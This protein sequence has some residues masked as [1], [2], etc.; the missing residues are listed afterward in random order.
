MGTLDDKLDYLKET[1]EQIRQ[2]INS[3]GQQVSTSDTFR[4]YA[5]KISAIDTVN[6]QNKTVT[7]NGVYSADAGYSGLGNVTV[8]LPL[9]TKRITVNGTYNASSDDLEGYSSVTVAVE[10]VP[11]VVE[12]VNVTPTTSAQIIRP[13]TGVDGFS[14]VNVS[15]VTSAI[16]NNITAQNIVDGVQILGVSGSAVVLDGEEINITPTTSQQVITPTSPRN[17]ITQATVAAVDHTIDANIIA[18][19]IKSGVEIL[20]VEGTYSGA[21]INNQN[22]NVT[23]STS[24]QE[25]TADNGY[26]GL[27]TVNVSAV[28]S[29]IDENI[30]AANIVDG[31]SILG[32]IGSAE[33]ANL[34]GVG[35]NPSTEMQNVRPEAPYNGF[36]VVDV[37][38]VDAT[39]DE[40]I[41]ASNIKSGVTIL[42][43]TGDYQGTVINN[44]NKSVIPSA[45]DQSIVA[46]VGYTGLGTVTVS[47][48]EDLVANNIKSGVNIF[49]VVGNVVESNTTTV[50]VTPTTS[51]QTITPE[52]P[53]NG[54]SS[55]T[56]DAVTSSIDSNISAGNIKSGVE[57]LGVEGTLEEKVLVDDFP[58]TFGA[59]TT[60]PHTVDFTV[61]PQYDGATH[62]TFYA[63]ENF[64]AEN[65][66][67][68]VKIMGVT[69]NYQGDVINNQ[70]K[71]VTP[72]AADQSITADAGYTG[73]GTVIVSGDNDLVA[74]NIKSGANIF[75]VIGS[76]VELNGTTVTVNPSTSAQVVTPE[77]PY[78]GF[79]Q[80]TVPAVT[81]SIDA[82]INADNIISGVTILGVQGTAVELDGEQV[83]ITPSTS[84]Q[85]ITPTTGNGIT[86]ATVS[87][88]TSSIDANIVA[89]NIKK[90]VTILGVTGTL[91]EG[92]QINNQNISVTTDGTYTAG[93]GYTGLGTVTVTA[94]SVAA[95][96]TQ[97]E[98]AEQL[99]VINDGPC[100][101]TVTM[102]PS[103][104][105]LW[106]RSET[107]SVNITPTSS[108]GGVYIY[109]ISIDPL[110]EYSYIA[111]AE[112]YVKR[113]GTIV[114]GT[115][116]SSITLDVDN[117]EA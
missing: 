59:N 43:V 30:Q 56:V 81:S 105:D 67:S 17:G 26:T 80:V 35:V 44:Q 1:K 13:E 31:V 68:G 27:G 11:A 8:S 111:S 110:K 36:A 14:V 70:N 3:K 41:Q 90:D 54:F 52:S 33:V 23:P 62:S 109:T 112:G 83:T 64:V 99:M 100:T 115:T 37:F 45:I 77:S 7:A 28:T 116:S 66:K 72:G 10:D 5:T 106:L 75:G 22:K 58:V 46:D 74:G 47:G 94:G 53:Y 2:A 96:E 117:E 18:G 12:E 86:Q 84:Q 88:V 21:V 102:S 40:N 9:D 65:I 108:S 95:T 19:N 4:S 6:N 91:E 113:T 93:A 39:I 103:N 57:I 76:V 61:Y 51:A 69:G 29:S 82:N 49:G 98:I 71:T 78:N 104:A 87:A 107:N 32:V 60:L 25:I 16:D 20:G 50:T 48:D 89:G 24:A 79:T 34:T 101:L 92:S 73:L 97:N 42:G 63:P 114:G 38:P 55:V 15:A 85:I